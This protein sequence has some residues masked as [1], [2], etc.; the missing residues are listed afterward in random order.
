[1]GRLQAY[2]LE[3]SE[4]KL[5]YRFI[6]KGESSEIVKLVRYEPMGE[7]DWNLAFGDANADESD[8]D[9]TIISNN[10]DM[11]Q[12][13]QTIFLTGLIFTEA[14]PNR[15]VFVIPVD[16]QRGLLYNRVFKEKQAEIE[17]YFSI[18]GKMPNK[19]AEA[20]NALKIYRS[21]ILTRK[22]IL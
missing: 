5:R 1:M 20:Y 19:K 10:G 15:R 21:F 6:S 14:Y 18:Q 9:D 12:I 11:R 17:A 7:G 8:F 22:T 3:H 4:D 2:L 13:I 16:A